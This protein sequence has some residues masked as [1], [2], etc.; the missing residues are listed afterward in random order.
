MSNNT[1][2]NKS[3]QPCPASCALL[4]SADRLLTLAGLAGGLAHQVRNPLTAIMLFADI[5]ADPKR[6]ARSEQELEMLAEIKENVRLITDTITRVLDFMQDDG[7]LEPVDINAIIQDMLLLRQPGM[8]KARIKVSF[9][10]APDLSPVT[11]NR[12][13]LQ[14]V[15]G[16]LIRNGAESIGDNG[17]LTLATSLEHCRAAAGD[18]VIITCMDSGAGLDIKLKERIFNPFF[19]TRENHPGL[20][21]F[22]ARR[23]VERHGGTIFC[24]S[25]RKGATVFVFELPCAYPSSADRVGA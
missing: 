16:N 13:A 12:K 23:I 8:T 1:S 6:F 22:V 9:S 5:L 21:L 25:G 20:G 24:R 19:S 11:G 18:K 15:V 2:K 7:S 17:T 3:P 10:P 4:E 14:Q